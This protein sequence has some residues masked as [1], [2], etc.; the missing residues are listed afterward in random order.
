MAGIYSAG[1]G[2][3]YPPVIGGKNAISEAV[4][5]GVCGLTWVLSMAA[6]ITFGFSKAWAYSSPR[7]DSHVINSPT[8]AIAARHFDVFFG[9]ADAFAHPGEIAQFNRHQSII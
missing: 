1:S 3:R 9:F 6:R 2:R 8:V 5:I 7:A 4:P